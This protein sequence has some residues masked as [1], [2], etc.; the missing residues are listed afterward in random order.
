M[1]MCTG[2]DSSTTF[3]IVKFLRDLAHLANHTIMVALLQPA[4][5]TFSM[6]DDVMLIA[7]GKHIQQCSPLD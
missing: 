4:P 2:L 7:E 6:F 5:E 1:L 3:Q